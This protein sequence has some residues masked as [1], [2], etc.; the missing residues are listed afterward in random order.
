MQRNAYFH[1]TIR[2]LPAALVGVL[3]LHLPAAWPRLAYLAEVGKEASMPIMQVIQGSFGQFR[4]AF[5][6]YEA[7]RETQPQQAPWRQEAEFHHR[8]QHQMHG[9]KG[10]RPRSRHTALAGPSDGGR[11]SGSRAQPDIGGAAASKDTWLEPTPGSEMVGHKQVRKPRRPRQMVMQH[12]KA[13]APRHE[14]PG[15][16]P[17]PAAPLQPPPPPEEKAEALAAAPLAEAQTQPGSSTSNESSS[18][19]TGAASGTDNNDADGDRQHF[20]SDSSSSGA[21]RSSNSVAGSGGKKRSSSN[22]N[23]LA[24]HPVEAV[25]SSNGKKQ[26]RSTS[27]STSTSN[28]RGSSGDGEPP[29]C[30]EATSSHRESLGQE[31]SAT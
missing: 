7:W 1:A 11:P 13:L 8:S 3:L 6:E 27:S 12:L 20:S 22:S 17:P 28:K 5:G 15:K 29:P 30:S 24:S 16:Q 19:R 18:S 21:A 4:Q 31:P 2:R 23:G 25:H 9:S 26:S 10:G 14:L